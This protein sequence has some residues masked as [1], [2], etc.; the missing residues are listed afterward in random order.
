MSKYNL[1]HLLLSNKKTPKNWLVNFS[2]MSFIPVAGKKEPILCIYT[3]NCVI[4]IKV[5]LFKIWRKD[6]YFCT[7]KNNSKQ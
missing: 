7:Q 4:S 2:N 3:Y 5:T 6:C 1:A